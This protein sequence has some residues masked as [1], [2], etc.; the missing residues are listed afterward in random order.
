MLEC[1]KCARRSC[2]IIR[3]FR[4]GNG[5]FKTFH[6]RQSCKRYVSQYQYK[7]SMLMRTLSTNPQSVH[8]VLQYHGFE[9]KELADPPWFRVVFTRGK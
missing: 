1:N 4:N 7:E 5:M 2:D 6:L 8:D 3:M 9:L